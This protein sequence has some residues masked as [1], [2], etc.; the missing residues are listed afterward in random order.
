L[1]A[2]TALITDDRFIERPELA[3]R[4]RE[5]ARRAAV[6]RTWGDCYGYLLVATGRAEVMV[7]EVLSAWDA[8]ALF[9]IIREAGG[10]FTDWSGRATA[11][12][13]GAIATNAALA[14]E[15]RRLLVPEQFRRQHG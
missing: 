9:P 1:E 14:E 10:I 13:S 11:F 8:A 5:V 15:V 6:T 3:D 2:A 12:G 4:W 7:D